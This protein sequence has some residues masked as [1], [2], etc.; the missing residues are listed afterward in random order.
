MAA[1]LV[2]VIG[3]Q[4]GCVL[5]LS[6]GEFGWPLS[7]QMGIIKRVQIDAHAPRSYGMGGGMGGG[8]GGGMGGGYGG[9]YGGGR[10]GGG[11]ERSGGGG[12]RDDR[13][14]RGYDRYR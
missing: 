13:Y 11:Y 10:Y 6:R 8:Y 2:K 4:S 9:G 3:S 1:G 7:R 14:D 12:Y 5:F